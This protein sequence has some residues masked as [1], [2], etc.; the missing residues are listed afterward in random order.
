MVRL[1]THNAGDRTSNMARYDERKILLPPP[2]LHFP[3]PLVLFYHLLREPFCYILSVFVSGLLFI[4]SSLRV[5]FTLSC[6]MK[7]LRIGIYSNYL[8][9]GVEANY[10]A[11]NA[12]SF[13]A[14]KQV[15][16]KQERSRNLR[17]RM[18]IDS[19]NSGSIAL[20]PETELRGK[21][22]ITIFNSKGSKT[23]SSSNVPRSE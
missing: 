7:K 3:R 21:R 1:N 10:S 17:K 19:I 13:G 2:P 12:R 4:T 9:H 14:P 16:Q 23:H 20:P 6:L 15:H 5:Y 22:E 11:G 18:L 8:L